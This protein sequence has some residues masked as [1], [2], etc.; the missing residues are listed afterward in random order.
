MSDFIRG[1]AN[2]YI[3]GETYTLMRELDRIAFRC[4]GDTEKKVFAW[5]KSK[6]L[7]LCK[8]AMNGNM[9]TKDFGEKLKS[10]ISE[11]EYKIHTEMEKIARLGEKLIR[12]GVKEEL[13]NEWIAEQFET[14][15]EIKWV[16]WLRAYGTR[17]GAR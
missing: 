7:L 3:P 16:K 13:V 2:G 4:R 5:G 8:I 17:A 1:I 12:D 9:T 14:G 6:V 10:W 11:E 15:E